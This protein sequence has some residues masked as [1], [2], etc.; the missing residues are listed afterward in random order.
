MHSIA[1]CIDRQPWLQPGWVPPKANKP[2]AAPPTA[3]PPGGAHGGGSGGGPPSD[4]PPDLPPGSPPPL[5]AGSAGA[6]AASSAKPASAAMAMSEGGA[7]LEEMLDVQRK[8]LAV[9]N[10]E[11]E[12]MRA[13][14]Q[15]QKEEAERAQRRQAAAPA[16]GEWKCCLDHTQN[17]AKHSG[18]R[19]ILHKSVG[20]L[21]DLC[22][23]SVISSACTGIW[24][25][26]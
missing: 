16:A 23:H 5:P 4:L 21:Q 6:A 22:K 25:G 15:R 18:S 26:Y 10:L 7:Q 3:V 1:D 8:L 11:M 20:G 19:R 17:G 12:E 9:K 13:E 14:L 24:W 2:K